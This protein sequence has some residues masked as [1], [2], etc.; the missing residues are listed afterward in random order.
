MPYLP[1]F[2]SET[3]VFPLEQAKDFELQV[4][5][6]NELY[7]RKFPQL[8]YHSLNKATTV[9]TV[10]ANGD[11]A[12]VGE[13]GTTKFDPVWGES[14]NAPNGKWEQ[15]HGTAGVV[16]ATAVELFAEPQH[17]H[18][19]VQRINKEVELRK[20]GFD[21]VRLLTMFTPVSLLDEAGV[22]IKHGDKIRWNGDYFKVED[23][24]LNGYWK[25]TDIPMYMVMNLDHYRLGG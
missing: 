11:R 21:K 1:A 19:R 23:F 10:V 13:T 25:N 12:P 2:T 17:I 16:A 8:E 4:R 6:A 7:R 18:F 22:T 20:Y 15:P 14:V 24:N 9:A 3:T 5:L